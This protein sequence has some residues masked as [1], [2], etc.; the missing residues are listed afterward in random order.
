MVDPLEGKIAKTHLTITG[1]DGHVFLHVEI[2]GLFEKIIV[3]TAEEMEALIVMAD[4]AVVE[5]RMTEEE[6]AERREQNKKEMN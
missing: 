2:E 5:S 3:L 4:A 1:R 6:K